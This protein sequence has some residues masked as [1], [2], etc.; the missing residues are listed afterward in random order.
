M[1]IQQYMVSRFDLEGLVELG[2]LEGEMTLEAAVERIC[3]WFGLSSIF[4][5][6]YIMGGYQLNVEADLN[7]FSIN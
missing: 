5:Y 2:V 3:Q 1:T 7:T 4:D 6:D